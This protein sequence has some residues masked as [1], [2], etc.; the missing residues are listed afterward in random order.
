MTR[1]AAREAMNITFFHCG[2]R[3]WAVCA[4][5]GLIPVISFRSSRERALSRPGLHQT[6]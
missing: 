2:L 6:K 5:V 1:I 4:I 3:A